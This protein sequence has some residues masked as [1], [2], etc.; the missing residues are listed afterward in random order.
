MSFTF[1]KLDI[2]EVILME[3]TISPDERGFFTEIFRSSDFEKNGMPGHFPQDNY[4]RSKKGVIRGLH[5]QLNPKAQGKLV[6]VIKGEII[7][8]A[9]DIRRGSPTFLKKVSV[10]LNDK[11]NHM[12]YIP[13]GFAHGFI[14]LS[15]EVRFLYKCTEEYSKEHERGIRFDD[16]EINID[17]GI[18]NPT[19][20]DKDLSLPYLKD[21]EV[22]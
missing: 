10:I 2:P 3:S 15:D 14:A 22:F 18:S 20:S 7:D 4:S 9:V 17:W 6:R 1:K 19:V 13:P 12:L 8:V 11:N 5:Y 21:A 16:P